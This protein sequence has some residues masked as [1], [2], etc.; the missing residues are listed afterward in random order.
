M[1][2][3][4]RSSFSDSNRMVNEYFF[5]YFTQKAKIRPLTEKHIITEF[6]QVFHL[7]VSAAYSLVTAASK[8]R[9]KING[10]KNLVKHL[11]RNY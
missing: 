2:T 4:H 9:P 11:L 6:H 7:A 5:K 1:F 10:I 3:I 8:K